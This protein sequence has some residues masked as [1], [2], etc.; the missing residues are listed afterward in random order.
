MFLPVSRLVASIPAATH[1]GISIQ[2][3]GAA[4]SSSQAFTVRSLLGC[5]EPPTIAPPFWRIEMTDT[6]GID[7]GRASQ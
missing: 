1:D 7:S 5:K 3:A 6:A 4:T 2:G